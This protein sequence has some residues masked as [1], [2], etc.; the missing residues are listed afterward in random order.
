MEIEEPASPALPLRRRTFNI[1]IVRVPAIRGTAH[2]FPLG[3]LNDTNECFIR[4]KVGYACGP[5]PYVAFTLE[6]APPPPP[7]QPLQQLTL[8][9]PPIWFNFNQHTKASFP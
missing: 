3:S 2:Y 8:N 4:V 5:T 7:N 6:V 9:A 1:F